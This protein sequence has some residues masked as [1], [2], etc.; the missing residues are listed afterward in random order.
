M[1][2]AT[3]GPRMVAMRRLRPPRFRA[4]MRTLRPEAV[5]ERRKGVTERGR[6]QTKP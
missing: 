5:A 1:R 4:H 6:A 3:R 2:R